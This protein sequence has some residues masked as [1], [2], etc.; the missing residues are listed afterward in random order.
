MEKCADVICES[1]QVFYNNNMALFINKSLLS[2]KCSRETNL[3]L[4]IFTQQMH[5]SMLTSVSEVMKN[6][7]DDV[8]MSESTFF[9]FNNSFMISSA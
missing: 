2:T 5:W 8:H 7:H 6:E 3:Q 4:Y 1:P 9:F